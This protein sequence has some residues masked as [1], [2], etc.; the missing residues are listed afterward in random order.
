MQV[1]FNL[2]CDSLDLLMELFFLQKDCGFLFF[3]YLLTAALLTSQFPCKCLHS[4]PLWPNCYLLLFLMSPDCFIVLVLIVLTAPICALLSLW[5]N[6]RNLMWWISIPLWMTVP[7][8][9]PSGIVDWLHLKRHPSCSH[10][11]PINF[12]IMLQW[13]PTVSIDVLRLH[14]H[15]VTQPL[16]SESDQIALY[17]TKGL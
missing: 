16:A 6:C 9:G 5:S 14:L 13:I 10:L 8:E 15:M 11:V 1:L 4:S 7:V 2:A 17:I 12:W 3:S